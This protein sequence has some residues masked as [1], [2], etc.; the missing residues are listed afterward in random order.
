MNK[1]IALN[2]MQIEKVEVPILAIKAVQL[3]LIECKSILIL[4]FC[5]NHLNCNINLMILMLIVEMCFAKF[6]K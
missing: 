3:L 5:D 1:L 4:L 2:K 6:I